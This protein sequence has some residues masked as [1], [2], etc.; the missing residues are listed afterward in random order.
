VRYVTARRLWAITE[1]HGWLN[2][3]GAGKFPA[4]DNFK[5]PSGKPRVPSESDA[6]PWLSSSQAW[7][8]CGGFT[9]GRG[10]TEMAMPDSSDSPP[11]WTP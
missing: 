3:A 5:L 8:R 9:T 4:I 10:A 1:Q 6:F 2:V 11:A 7:L